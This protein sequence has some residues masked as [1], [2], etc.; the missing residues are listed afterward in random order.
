[1]TTSER[2]AISRLSHRFGFGPRPGEFKR[3]LKLGLPKAQELLL[4]KPQFDISADNQPLPN[5]Y[6]SGR[7]P[8]VTS[9]QLGNFILDKRAQFQTMLFWWLDRMVI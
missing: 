3:L 9:D 1:M 8:P 7:R 2:L 4:T 6:D 5:V